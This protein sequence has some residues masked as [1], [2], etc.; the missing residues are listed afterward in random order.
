MKVTEL[1]LGFGHA[2]LRVRVPASSLLGVFA[3]Q[4]RVGQADGA[5]GP[6]EAGRP[7]TVGSGRPLSPD[8]QHPGALLRDAL[9]HPVGTPRLRDLARPGQK[10]VV[11]TSDLTRPC[12][13]E[14]LLPP[15]LDELAAAGVPD[16][17][18]SI[19]AALG[20]HRPMTASELETAVGAGVYRRVRVMN[21]DPSD[22]VRLGVT[23]AGTPATMA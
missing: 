6:A 23:S 16:E 14:R 1:E 7:N 12:P 11:V 8:R 18:V 17:D 2:N 9:A 10:V 3:P 15:V 5:G 20:L 13:S 21:H 22:V 19:V 4:E